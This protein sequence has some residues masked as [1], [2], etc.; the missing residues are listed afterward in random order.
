MLLSTRPKKKCGQPCQSLL[1]PTDTQENCFKST[2]IYI[3]TAPT[4]FGVITTISHV[5]NSAADIHQQGPDNICG[6]TTR[7]ATM[8]YFKQ[9]F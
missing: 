7:L 1:L 4:R 5:L 9:L 3:K 8:M 6:H 2:K